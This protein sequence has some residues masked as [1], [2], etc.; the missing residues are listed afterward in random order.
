LIVVPETQEAVEVA[1]LKIRTFGDPV[2]RQRAREVDRVTD[3]HR[4]LVADMLDTMRDA[5]GVGLAAPQ[6][7]VLE[8]IFVWEVEDENGVL[9][10][11]VVVRR[12]KSKDQAEEG[13]LSLP[14]LTYPVE[15]PSEVVVEGLDLDGAPQTIEAQE[16]LAR[17]VQHETDHLDGVLFIDHLPEELKRDALKILRDQA[18][19]LPTH[20]TPARAEETL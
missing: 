11:P 2:L 16:L 7:G 3:L 18:L 1:V 10:N 15:R 5:P 8:R 6:V 4:K 20:T 9:L 13:C 17:V 14:G 19:G 12:S